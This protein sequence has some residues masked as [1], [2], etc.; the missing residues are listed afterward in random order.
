MSAQPLPGL[1]ANLAPVLDHYGY[2]AVG[3]FIALEDFGVPLPGETILIAAAVYAGSGRFH[4]V[5][6][7][8][9]AFLAAVVGDNVGF[10]VRHLG[11]R[12][13]VLRF[14]KYVLL[15]GGPYETAEDVF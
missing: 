12:A 7:G 3:G 14:G 1:L 5:A 8:L 9:I 11:D 4:I 2:L 13:L 6:V 15:T 10:A